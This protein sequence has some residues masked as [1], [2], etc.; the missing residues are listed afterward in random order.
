VVRQDPADASLLLLQFLVGHN[1]PPFGFE[2]FYFELLLLSEFPKLLLE[3]CDLHPEGEI[4]S[5]A[6]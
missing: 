4:I 2:G 1:V 6:A 5:W 3:S